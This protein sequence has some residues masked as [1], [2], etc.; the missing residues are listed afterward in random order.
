ML[1]LNTPWRLALTAVLLF[2]GQLFAESPRKPNIILLVADDLGYGD[3]GFQGGKDVPTPHLDAL[4]SSGCRCTDGYASAPVCSPS[5]AGF[6]TG[7]YQQRF[8][9]EFNPAFLRFGGKGLGLPLSE[10]TMA[11]RLKEAGYATGH[12]GKWHLGEEE[13]FH[14]LNRGFSDTFGFMLSAHNYF[15]SDDPDFGPVHRGREQVKIDG[16]LTDVLAHEA[17][18]FI[19]KNKEKPF[20]V[21]LAFN[22]VHTPLQAPDSI[23]KKVAHIADPDRRT[24]LAMLLALDAAVGAVMDKLRSSQLEE[25]TLV[26]F[27]SDNGGAVSKF[28]KNFSTNGP[29]RGSKGD[30]WEGGIRVPFLISWKG[31]VPAGKAYNKPVITLDIMP[32]ALAAAGVA[33]KPEWQLDGANLLPFLT[34]QSSGAPHA[35]LAWRFGRQM[36]LRQGDWKLVR[37]DLAIVEEFGDIAKEPMLFNLAEDIGEKNDL[38]AKNPDKARALQAAWDKWNTGMIKP[39]WPTSIKGK[40]LTR[41]P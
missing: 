29:L 13:P 4:A 34:G 16:Y 19:E 17:C 27:F 35:E 6:L 36:A 1:C 3:P 7:R 18:D 22:A 24:Y 39:R 8:G 5:R 15:E 26:F 10:K 40:E 11:D 38:A 23:K 30:T 25:K 21:Y 37:P 41:E 14:P 33:I 31:Q 28:S 2:S 12:I 9:H 20:F 32:T